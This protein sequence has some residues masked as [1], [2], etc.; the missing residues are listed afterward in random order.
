MDTLS[1]GDVRY[2]SETHSTAFV[3]SMYVFSKRFIHAIEVGTNKTKDII[4]KIEEELN[5]YKESEY[6]TASTL[7]PPEYKFKP[8]PKTH[9]FS[10][11]LNLVGLVVFFLVILIWR[12]L[13]MG[14]L[15]NCLC[16]YVCGG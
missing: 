1:T 3:I 8:N 4:I 5:F 15:S 6:I 11:L 2:N 13:L 12:D 7:F 10:T 14:C 9:H 16:K